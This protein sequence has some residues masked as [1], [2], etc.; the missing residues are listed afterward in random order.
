MRLNKIQ[1]KFRNT[2]FDPD[3]LDKNFQSI[4]ISGG[5]SAANRMKVYRNNVMTSLSQAVIAVYPLTEKLVGTD[6]LKGAVNKYVI[7]NPPDQGNL[8]FYG[9]T[10]ADFIADYEPAKNLPYLPDMA[11]LEWA[12]EMATLADDDA[13]LRP[14]DL[15]ETPESDLPDL[16]LRLRA[17]AHLL[18]SDYPLGKI[19]D[20]CRAEKQDGN[21]DIGTGGAHMM[22]YRPK[23]Q[24]QMRKISESEFIF[25]RGLRD[26]NHLMAAT[27]WAS[28]ADETFD[29]AAVLQKHLQM[30]TFKAFGGEK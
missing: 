29:L 27:E 21:L 22:I 24:T 1:E 14:E 4:F 23:L 5:I 28:E 19:V 11:R 20:F 7:S 30:E 13:P 8:N 17:C 15:Q 9:A 12:W 18:E 2:I 10:F 16:R 25:L 3:A 6:F 26:G